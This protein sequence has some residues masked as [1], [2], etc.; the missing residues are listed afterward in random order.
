MRREFARLLERYG[1][2][3]LLRYGDERPDGAG[4]AFLQ[5]V[6]ERREDW[7]QETP[8]PLG[9]MKSDRFLYLGDPGMPLEGKT[10]IECRGRGYRVQA[11]QLIWAG[12][13][14]S[15]WWA[16]LEEDECPADGRG[17]AEQG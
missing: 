2:K 8:T 13:E 12:R 6:T 5:P 16:V 14:A 15:H 10:Q 7:R 4:R 11:A 9:V 17:E 1:E 3:V